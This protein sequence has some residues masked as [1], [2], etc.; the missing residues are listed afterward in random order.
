MSF[1]YETL[2]Y[3]QTWCRVGTDIGN[4]FT[5]SMDNAILAMYCAGDFLKKF[6]TTHD[7]PPLMQVEAIEDKKVLFHYT[8]LFTES[9][10][11]L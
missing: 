4:T 5:R 6:I 10:T 11:Q 1:S 9:T 7:Q 3:N 2:L 8:W